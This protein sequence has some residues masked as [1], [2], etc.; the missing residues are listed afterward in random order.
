[1]N[2]DTPEPGSAPSREKAP[3]YEESISEAALELA[4][5]V[6]AAVIVLRD[7]Q[8]NNR[9]DQA[10]ENTLIDLFTEGLTARTKDIYELQFDWVSGS[11]QKH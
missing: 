11:E 4:Y 5:I 8:Q 9:W 2:K 3:I 6:D 1:M 10:V 7:Q